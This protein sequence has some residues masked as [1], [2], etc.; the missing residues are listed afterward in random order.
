MFSNRS[1]PRQ[2]DSLETRAVFVWPYGISGAAL[3][4][5]QITLLSCLITTIIMEHHIKGEILIW[6]SLARILYKARVI[7]AL[8]QL[9]P[10]SCQALYKLLSNMKAG[11]SSS[12]QPSPPYDHFHIT[13]ETPWSPWSQFFAIQLQYI[14]NIIFFD[15]ETTSSST[16]TNCLQNWDYRL[17][18]R[19]YCNSLLII[20]SQGQSYSSQ[21]HSSNVFLVSK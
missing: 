17:S 13:T 18:R 11:V 14:M 3:S 15:L 5:S 10:S 4:H 9:P 19:F 6:Q 16:E 20:P 21:L 2:P 8:K 7:P 12:K 1:V